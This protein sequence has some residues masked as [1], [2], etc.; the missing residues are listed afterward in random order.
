MQCCGHSPKS[1]CPRGSTRGG[2]RAVPGDGRRHHNTAPA[3]VLGQLFLCGFTVVSSLKT[4][5]T[6]ADKGTEAGCQGS[7]RIQYATLR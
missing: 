7:F 2:P 1:P 5:R 3:F 6:Y 4:R